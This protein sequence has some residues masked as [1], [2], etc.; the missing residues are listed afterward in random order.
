MVLLK[1]VIVLKKLKSQ[2]VLQKLGALLLQVV[3]H[4]TQ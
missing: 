1:Y 2:I 4:L 3:S